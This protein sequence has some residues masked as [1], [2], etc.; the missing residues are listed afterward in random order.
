MSHFTLAEKVKHSYQ[1]IPPCR[2]IGGGFIKIENTMITEEDLQDAEA[3]VEALN[4][5]QPEPKTT[6]TMKKINIKHRQNNVWIGKA[7]LT[8]GDK[9]N[10]RAFSFEDIDQAFEALR[11]L[12]QDA[13]NWER[14]ATGKIGT[15]DVQEVR[16]Q[17]ANMIASILH[18]HQGTMDGKINRL[19]K[20]VDVLIDTIAEDFPGSF[21]QSEAINRLNAFGRDTVAQAIQQIQDRDGWGSIEVLADLGKTLYQV[22]VWMGGQH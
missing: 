20:S 9:T 16:N 11:A 3:I 6:N 10:A 4:E 18:Q 8:T 22:E 13:T 2:R 15:R 5:T 14:V 12:G 7:R 1:T 17:I 21:N 19:A